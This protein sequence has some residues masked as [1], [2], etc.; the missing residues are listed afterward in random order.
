L[1]YDYEANKSKLLDST[2]RRIT[3]GLFHELNDSGVTPVFYLKDWKKVYVDIAD[4]T[5]YETAM[6]LIGDWDHWKILRSN[7]I[8]AAHFD[9]WAKEV[10]TK[11]RSKAIKQMM[12]QSKTDKGAAAARWLAEAGFVLEKRPKKVNDEAAREAAERTA[13]DAQR[14]GIHLVKGNK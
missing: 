4:P 3:S 11:V 2:G 6:E 8:V 1:K 10:E 9:E 7:P 5:E 14:L 12:I 13:A